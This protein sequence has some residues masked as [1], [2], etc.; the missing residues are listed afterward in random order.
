[1]SYA[2]SVADL[3]DTLKQFLEE[4]APTLPSDAARQRILRSLSEIGA[5][6]DR[7]SAAVPR[8]DLDSE[9]GKQYVQHRVARIMQLLSR[10]GRV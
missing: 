1:M 4:E 2:F 9:S 3:D 10:L 8:L 7:L 6:V 5:E